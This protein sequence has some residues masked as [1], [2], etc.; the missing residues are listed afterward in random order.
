M[1]LLKWWC[2]NSLREEALSEP[3]GVGV[4]APVTPA[5]WEEGEKSMVRMKDIL[6]DVSCP[7][8]VALVINLLDGR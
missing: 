5:G 8:Q 2:G 4:Q 7:A 6:D 3:T 1:M